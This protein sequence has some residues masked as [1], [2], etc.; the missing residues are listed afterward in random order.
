LLLHGRRMERH[1]FSFTAVVSQLLTD[2]RM[3]SEF[4]A[5]YTDLTRGL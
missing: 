5:R 2:R 4:P 1:L 3:P